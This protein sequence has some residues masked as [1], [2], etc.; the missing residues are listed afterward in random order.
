[1]YSSDFKSLASQRLKFQLTFTVVFAAAGLVLTW[2]IMAESS[3]LHDYFIWH[4]R[5]PNLWGMTL[6]IP[7]VLGAL[8]AGNPHSPSTVIIILFT[9]IQWLIVGFLLSLPL[10]RLWLRFKN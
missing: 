6:L 1:M 10:S 9:V 2:L 5:L 8:L 7:Y 4:V 3:P